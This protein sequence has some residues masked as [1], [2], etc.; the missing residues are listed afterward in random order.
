MLNKK[1][2]VEVAPPPPLPK[3]LRKVLN[4]DIEDTSFRSIFKKQLTANESSLISLYE[5]KEKLS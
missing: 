2:S 1:P 3:E 5:I 4:S